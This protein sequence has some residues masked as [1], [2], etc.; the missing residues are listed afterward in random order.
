MTS[1]ASLIEQKDQEL[2]RV[3]A[4]YTISATAWLIFA[5]F[6]GILLAYKSVPRIL[7]RC[8]AYFRAVAADPHDATFYGWASIAVVGLAYMSLCAVAARRCTAHNRA[9]IGLWLFHLAAVAGTVALD[10]GYSA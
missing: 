6:V 2:G 9:W 10:L 4:G 3:F 7:I 8:M 5:T 1:A